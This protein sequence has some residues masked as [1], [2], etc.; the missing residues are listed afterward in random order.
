M[1]RVVADSNVI[2]SALISGKHKYLEIFDVLD[3]YVPDFIFVELANYEFRI[4]QRA[5][6]EG[7]LKAFT[8]ELFSFIT[9]IPNLAIESQSFMQAHSLCRDVDPEDIPFVA[10]SL[11]LG[12]PLW[13]NDKPLS[14]G[15][16]ARGYQQLISSREIFDVLA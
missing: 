16:R 10:L 13:T 8:Q 9:V 2:F 11:D 6:L 14:E 4:R 7:A 5:E 15:L 3:V 12:V 1:R